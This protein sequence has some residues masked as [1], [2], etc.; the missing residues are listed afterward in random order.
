MIKEN[1]VLRY[2]IFLVYEANAVL[3]TLHLPSLTPHNVLMGTVSSYFTCKYNK[4]RQSKEQWSGGARKASSLTSELVLDFPTMWHHCSAQKTLRLWGPWK[5][6]REE[7]RM[8]QNILASTGSILMGTDMSVTQPVWH[9]SKNNS[10][11]LAV[12]GV[13]TKRNVSPLGCKRNACPLQK[14]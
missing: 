7:P 2:W 6:V 13:L 4:E 5:Q 9:T 10:G 12:L 3:G 11:I 8:I 1:S 14:E